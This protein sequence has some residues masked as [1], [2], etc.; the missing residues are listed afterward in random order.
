MDEDAT[1]LLGEIPVLRTGVG[2]L[3]QLLCDTVYPL[4]LPVLQEGDFVF[5]KSEQ[6]D[7]ELSCELCH[8]RESQTFYPLSNDLKVNL[9]SVLAQEDTEFRQLAD[10]HALIKE[11]A[12]HTDKDHQH[13]TID[14]VGVLVVEDTLQP[15]V[16]QRVRQTV[17]TQVLVFL[18]VVLF[19]FLYPIVG[20]GFLP[21]FLLLLCQVQEELVFVADDAVVDKGDDVVHDS[22]LIQAPPLEGRHGF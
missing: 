9:L 12:H 4:L 13:L 19:L 16:E 8:L 22:Q 20:D 14:Y 15:F 10:G 1:V 6:L 3:N 21:V 17:R 5:R 18:L 2:K 7:E 11:M